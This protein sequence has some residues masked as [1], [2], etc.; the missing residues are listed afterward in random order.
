MTATGITGKLKALAV[1]GAAFIGLGTV[2]AVAQEGTGPVIAN[3][4]D[5]GQ[6]VFIMPRSGPFAPQSIAIPNARIIARWAESGHSD[7]TAEAFRHWDEDGAIDPECSVC[8]SSVGFR[9]FHGLDGSE[10]GVPANP[11][12]IGGVVDCE[13]CHS[14]NLGQVSDLTLPSGVVHPVSGVEAACVTCHA[15]RSA[16]TNVVEATAD[17]PDDEVNAELRFIN[18]HYFLGAA[19]NLGG[20]G[21]VGYQ[22]PGKT[23]SGRFLHAKPVATCVSCHDPHNLKIAE[24]TCLTCHANGDPE[25]IRIARFSFDGSGDISKGIHDDIVANSDL[26]LNAMQDYAANVAGTPMLYDGNRYPYFFADANDDGVADEADG[27]PVAYN[28][29]TPRLLKATF[30]WKAVAADPGA[31]AHNA[32]YVLE[33][34]YD[35]IE[36]LSGPL[37]VDMASRGLL[38]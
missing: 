8:H 13:T 33:L 20:Y 11:M 18:P 23:Y 26:L 24:T 15:G 30:N 3:G 17:L 34:I 38:R 21:R 14:P 32:P 5:N 10:P 1:I 22:Y 31:Y 4:V 16:G 29:W 9:S 12:P 7:A 37:G 6:P 35:S 36:D 25:D 28:A 2:F 27:R 19:I